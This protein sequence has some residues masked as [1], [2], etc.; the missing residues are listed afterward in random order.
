MSE[1]PPSEA[2]RFAALRALEKNWDSY[3]AD[4]LQPGVEERAGA[5]LAVLRTEPAIC[6]TSDGGVS[7]VWGQDEDL[8]IE[9]E[10]DGTV[11]AFIDGQDLS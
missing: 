1:V 10:P 8:E 4:P 7:L 5:I 2:R 9:V 6:M 11:S 3:D